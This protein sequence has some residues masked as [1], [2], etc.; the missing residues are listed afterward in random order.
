MKQK[1]IPDLDT[2]EQQRELQHIETGV[3][4]GEEEEKDLQ[5]VMLATNAKFRGAKVQDVSIPTPDAS[6]TWIDASKYYGSKYHYP[7]DYLK[8]SSTVEDTSGCQYNMDEVDNEFLDTYNSDKIDRDRCT[9]DEFE[10]LMYNFE[11]VVDKKQPYL[12]MDPSQILGFAEI[13]QMALVQDEEDPTFMHRQLGNQL[14]IPNFRTLL[15]SELPVAPRPLRQLLDKFGSDIYDHWKKRR[16]NRKGESV[17]AQLKFEDPSQQQRDDNDPYVCFRRREY[18]HARKTRRADVQGVEKLRLLDRDFRTARQLLLMVAQRELKKQAEMRAEWGVFKQRCAIKDLKRELGIK[19][20]DKDLIDQKKRRLNAF[21]VQRAKEAAAAAEKE[22]LR[23]KQKSDGKKGH[24][25]KRSF[26]QRRLNVPEGPNSLTAQLRRQQ[27]KQLLAQGAGLV[28][29]SASPPPVQPYVKLPSAK[30]PDLEMTTVN[31]VLKDKLDGIKKAVSDRIIK[32]KLQDEGWVN[33]TDDPYNP[34]FDISPNG[35]ELLRE[36]SHLPFSSIAS[37]LYTIE[38]SRQIDFSYVFSNSK[39]YSNND[40]EVIKVNAA[41]GQ[42]VR[43]DR[44]NFMPAFYDLAGED[45]DD[46]EEYGLNKGSAEESFYEK[47]RLNVSEVLF[48]LRKRRGRSGCLWIDRKRIT[49]EDEYQ[50]YLEEMDMEENI[51]D[52]VDTGEK[53]KRVNAYD[54]RGGAKRR[55]RSRFM[56]DSDLPPFNPIDPSRLN[57]I[58]PQTQEIRFG[59]MLLSKAYDGMHQIRQKQMETYQQRILYQQ[60]L[61]QQRRH[62]HQQLQQQPK[63]VELANSSSLSSRAGSRN[64]SQGSENAQNVSNHV[65]GSNN[66]FAA[67]KSTTVNQIAKEIV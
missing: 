36:R 52:S 1:D 11:R 35:E 2:E 30:I 48:K 43:N 44:H 27:Q 59:A 8:F 50:A 26:A 54:A 57:Q 63:A 15:D 42:V 21:R 31:T 25:S 13:K 20:E 9:E 6:K 3:E 61:L 64:Y 66:S 38:D 19:T 55:L 24:H 23:S 53:R 7:E 41:T 33:F 45:G 28:Q 62:Q 17:F 58:D 40:N 12:S 18:R 67:S 39:H 34:F 49:D 4:K 22:R 60:K 56:F 14:G 5:A 32:R 46:L 51:T 10:I 47:N 16:L 29:E 37:S 65:N